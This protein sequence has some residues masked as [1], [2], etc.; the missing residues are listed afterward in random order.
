MFALKKKVGADGT[1][2]QRLIIDAGQANACHRPPPTTNLAG[3]GGMVEL[4]LSAGYL[5]HAGF[6]G[7]S[8]HQ[9]LGNEGD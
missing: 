3:T 1:P 4:D 8:T 2:W 9:P 5:K 6:G 7:L